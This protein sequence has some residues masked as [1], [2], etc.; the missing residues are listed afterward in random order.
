MRS[1]MDG[2]VQEKL[3]IRNVLKE[4]ASISFTAAGPFIGF[5][6][7]DGVGGTDTRDHTAA[8]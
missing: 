8:F 3:C 1:T 4:S 5:I 7:H 6:I 2:S